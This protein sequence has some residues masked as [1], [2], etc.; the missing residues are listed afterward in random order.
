MP[1][2]EPYV[3][4]VRGTPTAEEIA[5]LVGVL[6]SRPPLGV[7]APAGY[8]SSAWSRSARP[9]GVAWSSPRPGGWRTSGLLR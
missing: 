3:R 2:P 7:A 5:A 1:D 8:A 9:G 4:V 6:L